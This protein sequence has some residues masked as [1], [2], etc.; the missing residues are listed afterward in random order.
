MTT[1][2]SFKRLVRT[3]MDKTGESYTAARAVLLT[4]EQEPASTAPPPLATSDES[5]RRR[6]GRGWEEWFDL[7]DEWGAAERS[8]R[9]IARWVAEQQ[10]VVPLAWNAQA[11]AGSYERAR[12]LRAVGEHED[13]FSVTASKTV[14]VPVDRLYEAFADAS[15]RERW[16]PGAELRERTASKPKSVRF[17]WADGTTRV[18]VFFT[19]KG[20]AKSTATVQHE[21]LAD[22]A[23][24]ERMK[25]YW[26]DRV[27][28]MKEALER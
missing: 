7:L 28:A 27:A 8:H 16:L 21:R 24:A 4:A 6:T 2:R 3:R 20:E 10:G 14:A 1:Q 15:R 5:I 26:R 11:V 17:D 18:N 23:E 25:A 12:G 19:A 9:E 22:A 13:G